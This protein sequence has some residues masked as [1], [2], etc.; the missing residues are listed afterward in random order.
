MFQRRPAAS[1]AALLALLE[2]LR[3]T[4]RPAER[5]L[6]VQWVTPHL[7]LLGAVE[8]PRSAYAHRLATALALPGAFG[9]GAR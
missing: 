1:K 9:H 4:E 7:A 2:R 3:A 8:V 5:L 6:D